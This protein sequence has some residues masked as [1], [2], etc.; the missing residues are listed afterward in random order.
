MEEF[1][2]MTTG[3]IL[4]TLGKTL[5]DFSL[6]LSEK[7]HLTENHSKIIADIT[8]IAPKELEAYLALNTCS[9]YQQL[10]KLVAKREQK[11]LS[12]EEYEKLLGT[13]R[14]RAH[15]GR[16]KL[17]EGIR[18]KYQTREGDGKRLLS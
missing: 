7:E 14:T 17:L 13:L 11:N 4:K 1:A 2:I 9:T 3:M 6:S 16:E 12:E 5:D 18:Q 8:I 10:A 15:R